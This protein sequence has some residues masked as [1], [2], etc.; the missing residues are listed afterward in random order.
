MFG[1]TTL[2][3]NGFTDAFVAKLMDVGNTSSF[4][5]AQGAGGA[6]FDGATALAIS[7]QNAYLVGSFMSPSIAFGSTLLGNQTSTSAGFLAWLTDG[8]LLGNASASLQEPAVL[9][10]NPA[11]N[12]VTLRR[13]TGAAREPLLLR[14]ALGRSVRQ[15]PPQIAAE[16]A[17]DLHGLPAGLY[18][19]HVGNRKG[20]RLEIE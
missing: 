14:D 13:P 9:Y 10:P 1:S 7:S 3:S 20:L 18:M 6:N 5:W 19:L 15:Y 12:Q 16:A 2:L 17:L 11:H 4:T 8:T